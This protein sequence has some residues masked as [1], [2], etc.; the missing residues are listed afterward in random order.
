[1]TFVIRRPDGSTEVTH[2]DGTTEITRQHDWT[3]Q[4]RERYHQLADALGG[5]QEVIALANAWSDGDDIGGDFDAPYGDLVFS[6]APAAG[7]DG[8]TPKGRA[9]YARLKKKMPAGRALKFAKR[10]QSFGGGSQHANAGQALEFAGEMNDVLDFAADY[11]AEDLAGRTLLRS[12]AAAEY[13]R[14]GDFLALAQAHLMAGSRGSGPDTA[15]LPGEAAAASFEVRTGS[16]FGSNCGPAD[17]FGRCSSAFH[18]LGCTHNTAAAAAT[19]SH[20]SALAWRDTLKEHGRL[21]LAD[22]HG[23][24]PLNAQGD[25]AFPI[26]LIEQA[27]G[28]RLIGRP[29]F[30]T[31]L[32]GYRREVLARQPAMVKD[33]AD[34]T[35]P[36][37]PFPDSTRATAAQ[38][39]REWP[40]LVS[41]RETARF[42]AL[43]PAQDWAHGRMMAHPDWSGETRRT[44]AARVARDNPRTPVPFGEAVAGVPA[45]RTYG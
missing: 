41:Q 27:S 14:T 3:P 20:D 9:I 45:P 38:I 33:P 40:G 21:P 23:R 25:P 32:P 26:E 43:S 36:G 15:A 39:A 4:Q 35:D 19:G 37:Q 17:D 28:Q 34:D 6:N 5:Q 2:P 8:L 12:H 16:R 30:E 31:G 42:P 11:A 24:V 18:D 1:M 7:G 13:R 44:R 22:A 29:L 10:A